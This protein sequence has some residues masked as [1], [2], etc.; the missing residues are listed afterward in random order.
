MPTEDVAAPV[1]PTLANTSAALVL[2]HLAA[3]G[4]KRPRD[5]R[6]AIGLTTG[7]V[8]NMLAR[9][10]AAGVVSRASTPD[11]GDA[12]A[13]RIELTARGTA[14]EPE[15]TAAIVERARASA[16]IV[17]ELRLLLEHLGAYPPSTRLDER[18]PPGPR[19][20]AGLAALGTHLTAAL[21]TPATD[22]SA[23]LALLAI[24][25]VGPC[26]PRYLTERLRM[27]T[28]GTSS[29]IDRLSRADL[30][31]RTAGA[32][33]ADHRA[34]AVAL[35]AAGADLVDVLAGNV[36]ARLD[37]LLGIFVEIACALER[38]G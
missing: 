24:A 12:R 11:G 17:R 33:P 4:P 8:S 10:E 35:T 21:E 38:S 32:D 2:A 1:D 22:P 13:V 26:R 23:A 27:T 16:P 37:A 34:V 6:S 7:G 25:D 36:E 31:S 28:A 30:V 20:L 9:L 5:V 18:P 29:T 3:T 15:L 14:V 19:L